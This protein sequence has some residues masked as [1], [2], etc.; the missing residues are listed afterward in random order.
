MADSTRMDEAVDVN[1]Q[2]IPLGTFEILMK[3]AR[4]YK[5]KFI[6]DAKNAKTE[7]TRQANLRKIHELDE[8]M[9]HLSYVTGVPFEMPRKPYR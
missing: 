7:G 3:A 9:T 8:H 4:S 2:P 1:G 6:R 5:F